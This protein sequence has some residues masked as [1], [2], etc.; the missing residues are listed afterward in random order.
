MSSEPLRFGILG[1]ANIAARALLPA[2]E[3]SRNARVT[4]VGTREPA[5]AAGFWS[6]KVVT[7]YQ[8]VVDA[9]EVDA[10][11]IPL[12]N[13]LHREWSLKA[14]AAGK[15][16]LC[17]KPLAL[18]AAEAVE[19]AAAA[20]AAGRLVMEAAM[21]RFNPRTRAVVA[22]LRKAAPA[23]LWA[24]F[25]FP[26]PR[27]DNYRWFAEMGGGALLD[28]GFYT[29][30]IARW[31]LGEPAWVGA[32]GRVEA[33]D[34]TV[35]MTLGFPAGGRAFL[36]ASFD[37]PEVQQLRAGSLRL[38]RP[39]TGAEAGVDPYRLMVE[40]F[41][42]AALNG[43]PAPLPL[44]DSIANLRVLDGVRRSLELGHRYDLAELGDTRAPI[45]Q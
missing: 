38:E 33:V 10:V 28:V 34:V 37:S 17:E 18:N 7:G 36:F 21:Y 41:S 45:G 13:H 43:L 8:A 12:P 4:V 6:G 22:E 42:E 5:R 24:S 15:H 16:V 1:A 32:S 25:G 23:S 29:V 3:G 44:E 2:I 39:F 14:L 40:E 11:Y 27:A 19:I 31:V 26:M 9:P 35:S 30:S 20:A